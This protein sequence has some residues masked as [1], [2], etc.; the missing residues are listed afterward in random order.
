MV[1][2][3]GQSSRHRPKKGSS[4]NGNA[5]STQ[6]IGYASS[7]SMR[8]LVQG[9]PTPSCAT[10][11]NTPVQHK[12]QSSKVTGIALANK[13]A[14]FRNMKPGVIGE[15]DSK[16]R[17]KEGLYRS[18]LMTPAVIPNKQAG[19]YG[20]A[21]GQPTTQGGQP[22]QS[23]PHASQARPGKGDRYTSK[24]RGRGN[25]NEDGGGRASQI[26]SMGQGTPRQTRLQLL[27]FK[28]RRSWIFK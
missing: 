9:K 24:D 12:L 6:S 7:F 5:T 25:P 20:A 3:I 8:G 13:F 10:T 15:S 4:S 19:L 17:S 11:E 27:C 14:S 26:M 16:S 23:L 28:I 1:N 2:R 22:N 18:S 21:G